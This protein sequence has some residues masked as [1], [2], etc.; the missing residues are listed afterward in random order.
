MQVIRL[1]VTFLV[2][3]I[4]ITQ[5]ERKHMMDM[6]KDYLGLCNKRVDR[7][8][9]IRDQEGCS[10]V[11]YT[12]DTK[13]SDTEPC[14][15]KSVGDTQ[16]PNLTKIRDAMGGQ[17]KTW[18]AATRMAVAMFNSYGGV[19]DEKRIKDVCESFFD[20]FPLSF[21][22]AKRQQVARLDGHSALREAQD[23]PHGPVP[24][25]RARP[26]AGV[27]Q[28]AVPWGIQIHQ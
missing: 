21:S 15:S 19:L 2:T 14:K 3:S 18:A 23:V 7:L 24:R 1:W 25:V 17:K 8:K 11:V 12:S 20:E 26:A 13:S 27:C 22:N 10:F 28:P 4:V 5:D 16:E 9:D 6:A